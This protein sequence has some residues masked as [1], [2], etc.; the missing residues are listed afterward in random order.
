ML[1]K[2]DNQHNNLIV[3]IFILNFVLNLFEKLN[4]AFSHF[5]FEYVVLFKEL[6]LELLVFI[7]HD[8][9]EYRLVFINVFQ[10]TVFICLRCW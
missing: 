8:K 5:D 7:V 1:S 3:G 10:L 4:D 9:L 6:W 2:E